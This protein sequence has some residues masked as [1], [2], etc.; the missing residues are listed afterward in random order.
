MDNELQTYTDQIMNQQ[1]YRSGIF[2][3]VLSP[4]VKAMAAFRYSANERGAY[5][6]RRD[7]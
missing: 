1:Q 3:S 2:S 5:S 6:S 4:I 7:Y